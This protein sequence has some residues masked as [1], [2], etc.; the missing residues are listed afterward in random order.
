MY[1]ANLIT[2]F[3]KT[4]YRNEGKIFGIKQEDRLFHM[5]LVGQTGTGKST[6]LKTMILQDIESGRGLCLIEPHGDLVLSV[7]NEIKD[8]EKVV[9]FD[10]T[11]PQIPFGY[12]PLRKVSYDKRA[13]IASSILEVLKKLWIDAWGVKLEHILRNILLALLD[14]PKAHFGNILDMLLNKDYRREAK[15]YIENETVRD[16]WEKEFPKYMPYDF[17]PIYN[18]LGGFLAYPI[19]RKILVENTESI[20]LRSI[21]D[22]GQILLVNLSK[23]HIGA[24]VSHILGALLISSL[25]SAAFT[26][27]DTPEDARRPFYVYLDEFHNYTTLSM[28]N[29]LSELRKF[30][31]GLVMAHQ[32]L[33]QL[34]PEIQYA[35]LGNVGT[36]IIFRVGFHDAA[37]WA[38][39]M[40]PVFQDVDFM[41]LPNRHIYLTLMIDGVPSK[42]FSAVTL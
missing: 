29:M 1:F 6:M 38:R 7:F 42:P 40:K 19:V 27:V 20:S 34:E 25:N 16:F 17:M 5:Y 9:Y 11:N 26:R 10:A 31:V 37:I 32:Y 13:L 36:K 39:E 21:M 22:K 41:H 35:I 8:T 15:R 12:N 18:K 2:G 14:Q 3:A 30:K 23:G 28:I 33:H 24:D 4:N